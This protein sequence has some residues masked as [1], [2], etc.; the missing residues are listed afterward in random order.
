[1]KPVLKI[2]LT[3][4]GGAYTFDMVSALKD[5]EEFDVKV[6]GVDKKN[7]DQAWYLDKFEVV[8]SP[9]SNGYLESILD[10][11]KNN[12]V[13]IIV[14]L[15]E[16]EA[17]LMSNNFK[18]FEDNQILMSCGANAE[19]ISD[20]GLLFRKLSESNIKLGDWCFVNNLSE[21]E[22]AA[23]SLGY[24]HTRLVLKDRF[25]SG[26][27]GIFV[28]DP[29]KSEYQSYLVDRFCGGG[30][31]DV[32]LEVFRIN[33][34]PDQPKILM[35]YYDGEVYDVDCLAKYGKLVDITQRKRWYKNPF[36][37]INE[38]CE[39]VQNEKIER[40]LSDIIACL[41]IN[42]VCDFDVVLTSQGEPRLLDASLRMSGS[43]GASYAAGVNMPAQLIRLMMGIPLVKYVKPNAR[44]YP[45]RTFV[46]R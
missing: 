38:G 3:S 13:Q 39:L 10:I 44:I 16:A 5:I 26:S 25:S 14:P 27:R 21:L 6:I 30:S 32:I 46:K 7:I 19:L 43:V 37:P 12:G 28:L 9:D 40:Y 11:C 24:P 1:M 33:H 4:I 35:T 8:P 34:I 29:A 20:K 31:L 45:V 15:S 36:S 2:L 41:N 22:R 17:I 18:I 23:I 42:G